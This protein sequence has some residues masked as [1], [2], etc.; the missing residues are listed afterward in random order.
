MF[1]DRGGRNVRV[2]DVVK[3]Y[4]E[5]SNDSDR[6]PFTVEGEVWMSAFSTLRVGHIG[7]AEAS[8]YEIVKKATPAEPPVNSIMIDT[9]GD[10]WQRRRDGKWYVTGWRFG[11]T[12]ET[13]YRDNGPLR[14]VDTSKLVDL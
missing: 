9:F 2:G 10:A 11:W 14:L 7:I 6:P 4:I 5:P 1:H 3:L 13:L 12:W 8:G